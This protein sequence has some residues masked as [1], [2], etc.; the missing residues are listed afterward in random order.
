MAKKTSSPEMEV[1][2]DTRTEINSSSKLKMMT[3]MMTSKW[4]RKRKELSSVGIVT[5]KGSVVVAS[6]HSLEVQEEA[7]NAG[8]E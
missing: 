4:S 2:E 8:T 1:T 6:Q 5:R 7:S 3:V